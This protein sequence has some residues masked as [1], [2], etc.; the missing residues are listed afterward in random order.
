MAKKLKQP[1][2]VECLAQEYADTVAKTTVYR[3]SLMPLNMK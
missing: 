2:K 1:M 3:K